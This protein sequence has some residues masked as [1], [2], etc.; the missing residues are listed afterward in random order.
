[1][2]TFLQTNIFIITNFRT[3]TN[4]TKPLIIFIWFIWWGLF[5]SLG[6]LW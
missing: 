3:Q 2:V 5:W 4:V 1:M 6:L